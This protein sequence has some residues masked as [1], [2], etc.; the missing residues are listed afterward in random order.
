MSLRRIRAPP[1]WIWSRRHLSSATIRGRRRP[2]HRHVSSGLEL[3]RPLSVST[4]I[5]VVT[6]R[7][8]C[9]A[10]WACP[11]RLLGSGGR[12]CC[13]CPPGGGAAGLWAGLAAAVG[14][15][16][17]Q[18]VLARWSASCGWSSVRGRRP[19]LPVPFLTHLRHA[20]STFAVVSSGCFAA[21]LYF[22][23]G[24]FA[25]AVVLAEASSFLWRIL[26]R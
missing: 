21:D 12:R 17:L 14:G 4:V 2:R 5:S 16:L 6:D 3:R 8:P 19:S 24:Y 11:C 26:G 25:V 1:G 10:P 22:T 9:V 7:R 20:M 23:G 15:G 18:L 13:G